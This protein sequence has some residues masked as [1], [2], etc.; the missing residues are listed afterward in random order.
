MKKILSDAAPMSM[1]STL[2]VTNRIVSL[3]T[4]GIP[5]P[6]DSTTASCLDSHLAL[7]TDAEP[8]AELLIHKPHK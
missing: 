8:P 7:A 3:V 1:P 2:M 4:G 5:S 6:K